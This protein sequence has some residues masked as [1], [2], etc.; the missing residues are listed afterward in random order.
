MAKEPERKTKNSN[1]RDE[2][3]YL[4]NSHV[5]QYGKNRDVTKPCHLFDK[6]DKIMNCSCVYAPVIICV[7]RK[8]NKIVEKDRE[9]YWNREFPLHFSCVLH[10]F[11]LSGQQIRSTQTILEPHRSKAF[12]SWETTGDFECLLP[13]IKPYAVLRFS[14][15]DQFIKMR[16]DMLEEEIADKQR[17]L[18]ETKGKGLIL[19]KFAQDLL[20]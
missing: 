11:L 1:I 7:L 6:T 9:N 4:Q 17:K 14:E 2:S 3:F 15:F 10:A 19:D 13:H 12:K 20:K 5:L 16:Q 8:S 18:D